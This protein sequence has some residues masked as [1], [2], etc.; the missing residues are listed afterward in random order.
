MSEIERTSAGFQAILPGCEKRTLPKSTTAS[1]DAGQ[2]LL[3]FYRPPTL[4]EKLA[5]LAEAPIQPSRT[6]FR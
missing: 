3:E 5:T 4:R 1:D 6:K 2:G